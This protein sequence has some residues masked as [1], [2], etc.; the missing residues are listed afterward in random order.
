MVCEELGRLCL[1]RSLHLLTSPRG[2]SGRALRIGCI[3]RCG[4]FASSLASV[5]DL[6]FNFFFLVPTLVHLSPS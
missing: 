6:P 3:I 1:G 4:L 2:G 5:P